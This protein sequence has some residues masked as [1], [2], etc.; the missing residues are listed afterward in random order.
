MLNMKGDHKSSSERYGR[1]IDA[2]RK[3][4]RN[5]DSEIDKSETNRIIALARAF[6]MMAR[7]EAEASPRFYRTASELFEEAKESLPSET[8]K[9]LVL[10]H[11]RYCRALETAAKFLDTT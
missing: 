3:L 1:V 7:A 10:G 4:Q 2:L 6:Q 9:R 8:E 11:S 5:F